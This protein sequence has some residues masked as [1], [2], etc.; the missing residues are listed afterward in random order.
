M[1]AKIIV[2]NY[3]IISE[4]RTDRLTNSKIKELCD[5]FCKYIA[6]TDMPAMLKIHLFP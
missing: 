4:R 3:L 6:F 1:K 2:P 5:V